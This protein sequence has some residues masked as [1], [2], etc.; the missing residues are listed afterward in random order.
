MHAPVLAPE[1]CY[2]PVQAP[3]WQFPWAA[4]GVGAAGSSSL[5]YGTL[6]ASPPETLDAVLTARPA[7]FPERANAILALGLASQQPHFTLVLQG[8][9]TITISHYLAV[10]HIIL[11]FTQVQLLL[12]VAVWPRLL[13]AAQLLLLHLN[14]LHQC[15]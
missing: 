10:F 9:I 8:G 13:P 7:G 14:Q 5:C 12:C 15:T 4:P 1:V 3:R 6:P 2:L 11:L